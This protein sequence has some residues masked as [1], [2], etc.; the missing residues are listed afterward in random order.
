MEN[1]T[2]GF[3][4]RHLQM[5][6]PFRLGQDYGQECY[7]AGEHRFD[8]WWYDK[9][10]WEERFKRLRAE[11]FN[12][13][14]FWNVH[15]FPLLIRFRKFP[16][17]AFF[18]EKETARNIVHFQWL[19]EKAGEYGLDIVLMEYI[20][21]CAPGFG[22]RHRLPFI[23]GRGWGKIDTPLL[24]AY[25]RYCHEELFRTYPRLGGLM[26]CWEAAKD[27]ASFL[28][29]CVVDVMNK[30]PR[31]PALFIR[32]W[33]AHFPEDISRLIKRYRGKTVLCEK[34]SQEN[35]FK[36][37]ADTRFVRWKQETGAPMMALFGP[38]N[39]T[40]KNVKG[41]LWTE[42]E[43]TAKLFADAR[44]KGIEGIGYF[45]GFDNWIGRGMKLPD[46]PLPKEQTI[47]A[48][49]MRLEEEAVGHYACQP[50]EK[51]SARLWVK[52]LGAYYRLN[53]REASFLF[54]ALKVGSGIVPRYC[55]LIDRDYGFP[56]GAGGLSSVIGP[57]TNSSNADF[58]G[59]FRLS[60]PYA[61][62][63]HAWGEKILS[64]MDYCRNPGAKGA[65]PPGIA[66]ELEA[67][68][69]EVSDCL[70]KVKTRDAIRDLVK[71]IRLN[72]L[73]G[74]YAG[75][76]IMAGVYL[77]SS[78]FAGSKK[79]ALALL[80][81]G[82]KQLS[83]SLAGAVEFSRLAA[84]IPLVEQMGQFYPREIRASIPLM[85]AE[86]KKY[87]LL[88]QYLK[89]TKIPFEY[90]RRYWLSWDGYNSL[91]H[92]IRDGHH[93]KKTRINNAKHN[94]DKAVIAAEKAGAGLGGWPRERQNV[95]KWMSFLQTES[96]RFN[97]PAI[98]LS[99]NKWHKLR[100]NGSFVP[101][102]RLEDQLLSFFVPRKI[103]LQDRYSYYPA[104]EVKSSAL[105]FK[106]LRGAKSLNLVLKN[107]AKNAK[108]SVFF[109]TVP[110]RKYIHYEVDLAGT[111]QAQDVTLI[112]PHGLKY[113]ERPTAAFMRKKGGAIFLS[114][115][116][117]EFHFR[118]S[119]GFNL[120]ET[121]PGATF[122]YL[123]M[124]G[125]VGAPERF[126]KLI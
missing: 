124:L 68:A 105:T 1:N 31:K 79:E 71:Y 44:R 11:G 4:Y 49:V 114:F 86:L 61:Y 22:R 126:T 83:A 111:I 74:F 29:E 78:V 117:Q 39:A 3:A 25:N 64:I 42:P 19:I 36:P 115:P 13:I 90:V 6:L 8:W 30:L 47:Y 95:I 59:D 96:N 33:G 5:W 57:F 69:G 18:S 99:E 113:E 82:G 121:K 119:C 2:R 32:L 70:K 88:A 12:G 110:G 54:R 27:N 52:K 116:G 28:A 97:R 103:I 84:A 50:F 94:L 56:F 23:K 45:A 66:A 16:E 85:K 17:A 93:I 41:L 55:S 62:P 24:R 14:S 46:E 21:H 26:T 67:M 76:K 7:Q 15:P 65:H 120:V 102:L 51:Y 38:G 53:N 58:K 107:P 75:R 118:K 123:P 91:Q 73:F 109:D 100:F 43:Y 20:I 108:I 34:M 60:G 81:K 72:A 101:P 35:I 80:E 112:P 87:R 106:V 125:A 98:V 9:D 122:S 63:F 40:G 10:W 92:Y 89:R 77:Y 104:A 37:L 48:K